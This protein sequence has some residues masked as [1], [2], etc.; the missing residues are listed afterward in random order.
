VGKGCAYAGRGL[1]ARVLITEVDPICALQAAMKGYEV[2]TI[3][4]AAPQGDIFVTAKLALL[5]WTGCIRRPRWGRPWQSVCAPAFLRPQP[6]LV[7]NTVIEPAVRSR[8]L[9]MAQR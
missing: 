2:V 8:E 7:G 4:E 3:E 5:R 6:P 1:G 9:R